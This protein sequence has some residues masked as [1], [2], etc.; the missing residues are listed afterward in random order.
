[1][2]DDQFNL[3]TTTEIPQGNIGVPSRSDIPAVA[4]SPHFDPYSP[5]WVLVALAILLKRL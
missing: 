2:Q 1:M 3:G 4:N 5:F